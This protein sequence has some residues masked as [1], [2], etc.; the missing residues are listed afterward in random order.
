MFRLRK[1]VFWFCLLNSATIIAQES[2]C[3]G[4]TRAGRLLNGVRLPIA[5]DNFKSYSYLAHP[6]GRTYVHSGVREI[7]VAAYKSLA[8]SM[9]DA[10]FVYGET[11]T[12]EGGG[13]SPHKTHQ[14]GLS[15]DFMVPV[16]DA[17]GVSVAMPTNALNQ[18]GYQLEFNAHGYG[19]GLQIDFLAMA[20]HI[21]QLHQHA[22]AAGY[23]IWRV[24]FDPTLRALLRQ[25]A[26]WAY[27]ERHVTFSQKPS[28]VRH[29]E[30]YHVDFAIP[31]EPLDG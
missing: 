20:E 28:W 11:G 14:N 21:Y 3:Y 6:L 9:P 8:V 25:S 2:T 1:V 4:T 16:L 10:V 19:N 5:G 12:N 26:R 24:I 13:F 17:R 15:V 22:R 27:L 7:T 30:H 31:C 18:W 29:D 23:E